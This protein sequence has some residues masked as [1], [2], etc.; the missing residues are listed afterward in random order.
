MRITWTQAL[1][2]LALFYDSGKELFSVSTVCFYLRLCF[3]GARNLG[4][5]FGGLLVSW[6]LI[7]CVHAFVFRGKG[8]R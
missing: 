5:G 8:V 6:F 4:C 7:T 1:L 3:D 2:A